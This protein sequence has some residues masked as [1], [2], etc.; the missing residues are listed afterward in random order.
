[1]KRL[2][3]AGLTLV[4]LLSTL[5]VAEMPMKAE[6]IKIACIVMMD[7][8]FMKLFSAGCVA[9][10]EEYGA[11]VTVVNS[12]NDINREIDLINTYINQGYNAILI[13][14]ND[15]NVSHA[16]FIEAAEAGIL[17][18]GQGS[19]YED[20]S[21]I[22]TCIMSSQHSL[23]YQSGTAAVQYIREN[24][25]QDVNVGL[26]QFLSL[27]EW[28]SNQRSSGFLEALDDAG[29][30]YE[31]VAN[32][33]AWETDAALTTATDIM[34]AHPELNIFYGA[35]E[36]STVGTAMAVANAGRN[37]D[38]AVFGCD[39]TVQICEML[40]SEEY[41]LVATTAQAA[42]NV[43]HQMTEAMIWQLT[44]DERAAEYAYKLM[45]VEGD[46]LTQFDLGNVEEYL[47]S[48]REFI[49]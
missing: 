16:A 17:I 45:D 20:A 40:L 5:A 7:D 13:Q 36:G 37:D 44:G 2:L 46:L 23:G 12:Q 30:E 49:G 14:S 33:D 28:H 43:S 31:V 11:Y 39:A 8:Q 6:E 25:I 26:V 48:L 34:T 24:N 27:S 42:F 21:C 3:I 15:E 9:A 41:N 35:N 29:I 18:G 1:M 10:A 4:I 38:V 32:Q 47:A 22:F 19:S